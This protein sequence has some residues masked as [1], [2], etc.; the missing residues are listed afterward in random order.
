MKK[1]IAF[2]IALLLLVLTVM[3]TLSACLMSAKL[4]VYYDDTHVAYDGDDIVSLK[5][6][7]TVKYTNQ[8]GLTSVVTNYRI[9]GLLVEGKCTVTVK[10]QGVVKTFEVEVLPQK[11]DDVDDSLIRISAASTSIEAGAS[12][13]ISVSTNP[14]GQEAQVQLQLL[15]GEEFGYLNGNVFHAVAAGTCVIVGKI[16]DTLSNQLVIT[17]TKKTSLNVTITLSF[18]KTFIEKNNYTDMHVTVVPS[19]YESQ[20]QYRFIEG[21]DCVT[22][23]GVSLRGDKGGIVKVQAYVEDC[24][25]NVASFQIADPANDP[26]KNVSTTSFYNNYNPATSLEDAYW[27]TQ[28]NLMSGSIDDQDQ[29]PTI[30]AN[31][32]KSGNKFVRNTDTYYIDNRNTWEVV[33]SAGNVVNRVYKF[34]AYVTL[35]EVA[36]YVYAF[37][38]VP[39]NYITS[40]DTD[41]L[42]G[43]AWGKY[44]RLNHNYFSGNTKSYP[45]EPALPRISG[46]GNG[47]LRYYEI[48]IGTTGTDCDPRYDAVVYN[49]GNRIVRGAARIVYSRYYRDGNYDGDHI[50]DLE[51]RYVFYT[52]NHYNDFQEY[53]NYQGGWGQIFGNIT[54]GG[55]ISSKSDYNPTPYVE[56]Y[57]KSFNALF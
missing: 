8:L 4:A 31:Q 28:H 38:D 11:G 24:V 54:G 19:N 35:E 27:R 25:S 30:A 6:Y 42:D 14:A 56:V 9:I 12:A 15:Q 16:G 20:V 51:E 57:R 1:K 45:Y 32:P 29:E 36:A 37:G 34:G 22:R 17:V 48:D 13:E 46:I 10:Y 55:A 26:Y 40:N 49:N 21:G 33:D 18:S 50:D 44:L 7:L 53:L 2:T 41:M 52:Y 47:D 39:A 3:F 23:F 5:P 43:N